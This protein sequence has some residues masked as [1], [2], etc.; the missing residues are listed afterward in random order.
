M[1]MM[2]PQEILNINGLQVASE[3]TPVLNPAF[4]VTPHQYFSAIIT[5]RRAAYPPFTK[6]LRELRDRFRRAV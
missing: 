1:K 4:D 3:N 6:S 2:G 5:E